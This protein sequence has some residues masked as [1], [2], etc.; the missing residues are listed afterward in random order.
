MSH[1]TPI[2][3]FT[4]FSGCEITVP[5]ASVENWSPA[6]GRYETL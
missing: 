3:W 2:S 6:L 5:G 4:N 1:F